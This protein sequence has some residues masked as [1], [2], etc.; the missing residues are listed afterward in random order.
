MAHPHYDMGMW[1]W[2]T[3]IGSLYVNVMVQSGKYMNV[4]GYTD[5]P[6]NAY[7][8]VYRWWHVVVEGAD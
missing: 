4:T 2:G 3:G 6:C 8:C 1:E 5:L 7:D